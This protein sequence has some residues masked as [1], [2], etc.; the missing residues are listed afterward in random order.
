MKKLTLALTVAALA[1]TGTAYAAPGD[2]RPDAPRGGVATRA[3]AQTRAAQRFEQLDAN[4]DGK[5]DQTD[6]AERRAAMLKSRFE[7]LDA[8]H[9]GKLSLGE[10]ESRPAMA[11]GRQRGEMRRGH[12]KRHMAMGD[13]HRKGHG[14][15]AGRMADADHDGAVTQAEFTAAALQRF[16]RLDANHDGSVT[17]EERQAMRAE[18]REHR[19]DRMDRDR[20]APPPAS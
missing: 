14:M 4:H 10:F 5:I 1:L 13:G 2:A 20:A 15:M 8:D 17:A 11:E 3:E 18:W 6:R 9:D 12:G 16:D 19:Q 7:Q